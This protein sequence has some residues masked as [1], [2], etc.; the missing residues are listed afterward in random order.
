MSHGFFLENK[1]NN[2]NPTELLPEL[3]IASRYNYS[4]HQFGGSY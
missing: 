1:N 3:G 2:T 4:S